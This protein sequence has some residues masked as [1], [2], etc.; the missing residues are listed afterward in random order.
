M[1]RDYQK[2]AIE[3]WF[4]RG[5]RG[6]LEM[7]TATGK[8]FT[9]MGCINRMQQR[10]GRLFTVIVVPYAHLAQQWID[11]VN[12]WN[13]MV[14]PEQK[15][16]T[17]TLNT[18]GTA[19]WKVRLGEAVAAFNKK[20]LGG[21]YVTDDYIVCTT[22]VT[23]ASKPF[24]E[25][26]RMVE[27]GLL[28]VADEAHHAGA[29]TSRTG[30]LEEYSA[31]L[32]LTATPERYFDEE[33]SELIKSYFGN[34][35][36]FMDIKGAIEDGYLV[37]YDYYPRFV[38]MNSE[39]TIEYVRLTKSIAAKLSMKKDKNKPLDD[40]SNSPENKRARLVAKLENKYGE[41]GINPRR[42]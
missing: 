28:L 11:N 10:L 38:E 14:A 42:V 17:N 37:P 34:V 30:L 7:P 18:V 24:I 29:K 33:G 41:P 5:G 39:E 21:G 2:A 27:G 4:S 31:R 9:A 23:L 20:K 16:S 19:S 32:A 22:Y 25:K 3:A 6:I 12:R 15:I 35:A 40:D 8:T 26:I 13:G 36:Y 1:L